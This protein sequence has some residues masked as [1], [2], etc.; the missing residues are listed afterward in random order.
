[1]PFPRISARAQSGFQDLRPSVNPSSLA[2]FAGH[3]FMPTVNRNLEVVIPTRN[4]ET[5]IPYSGPSG[6]AD[7]VKQMYVQVT[8]GKPI[9]V[10]QSR[11]VAMQDWDWPNEGHIAQNAVTVKNLGD[12]YESMT[13][14]TQD[15]PQELWK[16]YVTPG[17]VRAFDLANVKTPSQSYGLATELNSDPL[18]AGLADQS[19]GWPARISQK[20][21][22]EGDFVAMPIGVMGQGQVNPDN[23]DYVRRF[24]DVPIMENRIVNNQLQIPESGFRLLEQQAMTLPNSARYMIDPLLSRVYKNLG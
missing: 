4:A 22:R 17:G 16:M 21:G 11:N 18:Y 24:H 23:L 7:A 1:M 19:D 12:V 8:K 20:I 2:R 10:T 5:A 6:R 13:K 3:T 15:N 9:E 14:F